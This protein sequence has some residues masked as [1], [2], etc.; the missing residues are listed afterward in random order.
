MVVVTHEMGFARNVANRQD[1]GIGGALLLIDLHEAFFIDLHLGVFKSQ[2]AAVRSA[3][4]RDQHT[5]EGLWGFDT[6][7]FKFR[8]DA[9]LLGR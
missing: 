1:V 2:I 6:S 5:V 9:S 3:A 7:A 8:D 4:N